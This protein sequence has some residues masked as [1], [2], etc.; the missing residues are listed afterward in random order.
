MSELS[1]ISIDELM[2]ELSTRSCTGIVCIADN[3][4][5]FKKITWGS[6]LERFGIYNIV[7]H[8]MQQELQMQIC[9]TS[10]HDD[11]KNFNHG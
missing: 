8:S 5:G 6:D 7:G 4:F 3:S 10:T 1:T 11:E 2:R 9:N